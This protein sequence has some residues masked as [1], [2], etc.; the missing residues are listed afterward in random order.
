ME[1]ENQKP[2]YEGFVK[3][4]REWDEK[5]IPYNN[6]DLAELA[7]KYNTEVPQQFIVPMKPFPDSLDDVKPIQPP[8]ELQN[9]LVFPATTEQDYI[10]QPTNPVVNKQEDEDSSV[11]RKKRTAHMPAINGK[12]LIELMA[13]N[14]GSVLYPHT[15]ERKVKC[16]RLV[17]KKKT[18]IAN[19]KTAVVNLLLDKGGLSVRHADGGY[20]LNDSVI[21]K[22]LREELAA[23]K[24]VQ[25]SWWR[26]I[27]NTILGK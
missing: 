13:R 26:K 1:I 8:E 25:V 10:V 20:L 5:Y 7:K 12:Q 15:T 21:P 6:Q 3:H 18:P 23:T 14:E 16:Y 22:K 27:L 11:E 19:I 24:Q 4:V 2:D 9:P 17:D